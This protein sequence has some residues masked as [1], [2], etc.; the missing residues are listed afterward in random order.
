MRA[1]L[2]T[3]WIALMPTPQDVFLFAG[4]STINDPMTGI[5]SFTL[6]SLAENSCLGWYDAGTQWLDGRGPWQ[7]WMGYF[8]KNYVLGTARVPGHIAGGASGTYLYAYWNPDGVGL[9]NSYDNLMT[10]VSHANPAAIKAAICHL[11]VNTLF[12]QSDGG[13]LT[14]AQYKTNLASLATGVASKAGTPPTYMAMFGYKGATVDTNRTAYDL[15]RQAILDKV[16]DGTIRLGANLTGQDYTVNGNDGIH[17]CTDALVVE[18]GRA[19]YLAVNGG[20]PAPRMTGC[21]I[22]PAKTVVTVTL[23]RDLGNTLSSSVAAFRVMD[24]GTSKTISTAVVTS[25]RVITLTLAAPIAGTCTV[26]FASGG[27]A[28]GATPL[29]VGVTQNTP[30]GGTYAAPLVPFFDAAVPIATNA[31]LRITKA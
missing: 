26:S 14:L 12:H 19:W 30:D 5:S 17:F 28:M 11:G 18:A 9:H 6:S 3:L 23:D 20:T 29:P 4:D 31:A 10:L 15:I 25:A 21:A 13:G 22:N 27:D 7:S 2:L 8:I 24:S 1:L 16:D